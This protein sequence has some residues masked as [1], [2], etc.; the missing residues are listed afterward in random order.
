MKLKLDRMGKAYCKGPLYDYALLDGGWAIGDTKQVPDE[1]GY[2][3]LAKYPGLFRQMKSE[4]KIVEQMNTKPKNKVYE[5]K[6][7]SPEGV[8]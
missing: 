6:I 1:R 8:K 2:Q 5:D 3:L 4:D 7:I